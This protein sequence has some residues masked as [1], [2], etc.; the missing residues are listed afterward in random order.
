VP[1]DRS[2][3]AD[4]GEPVLAYCR[5][6]TETQG[7]DGYSLDDQ[8]QKIRAY[9]EKYGLV[10]DLED[11]FVEEFSGARVYRPQMDRLLF[12]AR[13]S[14]G[15]YRF[16]LVSASDRVERFDDDLDR[17]FFR[18][19]VREAGLSFIDISRP[20]SAATDIR[21]VA[22]RTLNDDIM[23]AFAG[24]E[25]QLILA[26]T[27]MG[28]EARAREDG[29]HWGGRRPFGYQF[30]PG[31]RRGKEVANGRLV[32]DL[33]ESPIV[34]LIYRMFLDET[35]IASI[36]RHLNAQYPH[37]YPTG[38][39]KR[40]AGHWS[41]RA[42]R[43]VLSNP[44]YTGRLVLN[45]TYGEIP[46]LPQDPYRRVLKT[47][48]KVRPREEWIEVPGAVDEIL[49]RS[50]WLAA[51][52]SLQLRR[53]A[54][55]RSVNPYVLRG[56]LFHECGRAG[57]GHSRIA[58]PPSPNTPRDPEASQR[59]RAA[60][61]DSWIQ[62]GPRDITPL[63]DSTERLKSLAVDTE[64][65]ERQPWGYYDPHRYYA[66]QSCESLVSSFKIENAIWLWVATQLT[67]PATLDELG[68]YARKR[69][70]FETD[71]RPRLLRRLESLT[72]DRM[73]LREQQE[74][75]R[76]KIG[77]PGWTVDDA[78]KV[79]S[80]LA[81][82][83]EEREREIQALRREIEE[84]V[85]ARPL[86]VPEQQRAELTQFIHQFQWGYFSPRLWHLM[87]SYF[88][89]KVEWGRTKGKRNRGWVRVHTSSRLGRRVETIALPVKVETL[90]RQVEGAEPTFAPF[91]WIMPGSLS[92]D[93]DRE[94]EDAE[95]MIRFFGPPSGY[96]PYMTISAAA[97]GQDR[98]S[99][100]WEA[101]AQ[102]LG[103][104]SD[105][106]ERGDRPH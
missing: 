23:T 37:L 33:D 96:S 67:D 42:V 46:L 45:R 79:I 28:R 70:A 61:S 24:Y 11:V 53:R 30:G 19:M 16:I 88:V 89:E 2:T 18:H 71:A 14:R 49:D 87:F 29:L 55:V 48:R 75:V 35:P 81:K 38:S 82:L 69:K 5:V 51:Q 100:M 99:E 104:E 56:L 62:R 103:V 21:S 59:D 73:Q 97:N 3:P 44:I 93:T 52:E 78:D 34:R 47:S 105:P 101:I 6:S 57:T 12:R 64:Q 74:A 25:R 17:A 1:I 83:V 9:A 20:Y 95:T 85:S 10:L 32:E 22:T 50:T 58:A 92:N 41:A 63:F 86:N 106:S 31:V 7:D 94:A 66:C 43:Y 90:V 72:K 39:A 26:R 80:Q 76:A 68:S 15:R 40:Q 13:R 102:G 84:L 91:R 36:S 4:P 54:K 27:K 60:Y 8:A 77:R 65:G 98:F